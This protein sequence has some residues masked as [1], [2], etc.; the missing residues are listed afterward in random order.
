MFIFMF[1]KSYTGS[2]GQHGFERI[3]IDTREAV[4]A[5]AR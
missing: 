4:E 5:Q 1:A 2:S 3:N